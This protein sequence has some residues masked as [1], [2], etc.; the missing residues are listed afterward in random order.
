MFLTLLRFQHPL[1][2]R[3]AWLRLRV[4]VLRTCGLRKKKAGNKTQA[5]R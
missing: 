2:C 1:V 5:C 3:F 4:V